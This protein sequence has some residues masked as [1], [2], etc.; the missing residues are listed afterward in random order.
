MGKR[1][2][3]VSSSWVSAS[4]RARS[5]ED[6]RERRVEFNNEIRENRRLQGGGMAL[7]SF[8]RVGKEKDV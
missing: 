2:P 3:P 5:R 6:H 8:P 1:G 4:P 7:M